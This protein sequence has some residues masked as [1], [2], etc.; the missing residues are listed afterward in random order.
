MFVF[1]SLY[2]NKI[3]KKYTIHFRDQ[4]ATSSRKVEHA[5]C[6][7]S[8]RF[9]SFPGPYFPA[10]SP[11]AGKYGP[12]KLRIRALFTQWLRFG[13]IL[14]TLF[15]IYKNNFIRTKAL[16]LAKNLKLTT[17]EQIQGCCPAEHMS[18]VFRLAISQMIRTEYQNRA[19]VS[20]VFYFM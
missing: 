7:K 20:L 9:L 2:S 10:F 1:T 13:P 8:V 3:W 11:N 6:V 15:F 12:Q 5:P 16:V 14:N 4:D 18:K 19:W 17:Q